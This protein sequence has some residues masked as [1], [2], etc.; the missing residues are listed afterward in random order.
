MIVDDIEKLLSDTS[1]SKIQQFWE[2]IELFESKE[3]NKIF[4]I[5]S[6]TNKEILKSAALLPNRINSIIRLEHIPSE[7]YKTLI[8][9]E[10]DS[11]D[12]LALFSDDLL[13]KMHSMNLTA[14]FIINFI[15]HLK[16][17][18][19]LGNELNSNTVE[20]ILQMLYYS[21]YSYSRNII[22]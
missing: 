16:T 5:I 8:K 20:K 22:K 4:I 6:T 1:K 12:I 18:L 3:N 10:T 19:K 14:P 11:K 2:F 9:R 7:Y 21:F 13:N 15:N 17:E